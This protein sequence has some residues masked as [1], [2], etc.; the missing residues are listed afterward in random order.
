[1]KRIEEEHLQNTYGAKIIFEDDAYEESEEIQMEDLEQAPSKFEDTQHQVHDP[2]EEVNLGTVEESRITYISS[3]LPSEFKEGVIVTLQEFKDYF[4]WNYD[5]ILGLD[6]SLV[7]HRLPIK[8]EFHPFQKPPRRMSKE[9]ELKVKE[10]IEKIL[11]AKFIIPTRCLQWLANII[12]MMKKNEKLR[13]CVDFRNLNAATPKDMYVMPIADMLVNSTANNEFL[14][15]MD[16]FFG[17]NQILIVVNDISKTTFKC[18]G[19][20]GTFEWLVMPFGLKNAGA[21]YQRVMNAIFHDML[22]HHMEIY[23]DHIVVKSKKAI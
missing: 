16:G 1:M 20:L 6:R 17:Y 18:S 9:V 21:T 8:P 5:E 7:E 19:S 15:F 14:F 2:M 13:V 11:K 12:P 10:E 4:A 3:L 23:I 22:G